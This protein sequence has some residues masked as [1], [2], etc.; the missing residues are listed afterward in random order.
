MKNFPHQINQIHKLVGALE[1]IISLNNQMQD[2]FD[3]GILGYE[4]ARHYVYTFRGFTDGND[5]EARISLEQRKKVSNQGART[6]ARDLRRLFIL[7]GFIDEITGEVTPL[8]N[9]IIQN[10]SDMHSIE[11]RNLWRSVL[12]NMM[13]YSD[14]GQSSHPYR[15]LIRLVQQNNGLSTVKLALALEA[16]NDTEEEFNRILNISRLDNWDDY[17]NTSK[18]Q[19]RN[20]VK[21]LPALARQ[22]GDIRVEDNSCYIVDNRYENSTE[23]QS[24]NMNHDENHLVENNNDGYSL[25]PRSRRRSRMVT[26]GEIATIPV[27]QDDET[28]DVDNTIDLTNAI[29]TRLDRSERHNYLVRDFAQLLENRGYNLAENPMDC[30]GMKS[31]SS[32]ILVEVKTLNR[33]IED[34]R[35]QVRLALAQLLYYEE[36]SVSDLNTENVRKIALFESRISDEHIQFLEHYECLP[37]WIND[38]V[39]N[40]SERAMQFFRNEN[41]F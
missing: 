25:T 28:S 31:G 37:I 27:C 5:L 29:N 15:I 6:C 11:A 36:F 24:N 40:G 18:A 35:K 19:L 20:A 32:S 38:G 33:T 12:D 41:V 9:S 8:G 22:I 21:I 16:E 4:L 10:G 7:L 26:A 1:V 3:D 30:L 14:D 39:I 17:L 2:I 23:I 13:L 34:E